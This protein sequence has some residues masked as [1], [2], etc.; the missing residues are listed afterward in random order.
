MHKHSARRR[1]VRCADKTLGCELAV[2]VRHEGQDVGLARLR[3]RRLPLEYYV[4]E[5]DIPRPRRRRLG[6]RVLPLGRPLGQ[7]PLE[8]IDEVLLDLDRAGRPRDAGDQDRGEQRTIVNI[9]VFVAWAR[10]GAQEAVGEGRVGGCRGEQQE[11]GEHR[12]NVS[13]A[14]QPFHVRERRRG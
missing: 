3:P 9:E 13:Q 4:V 12:G 2:E 7:L 6:R 1:A 5:W 14:G 10:Y 11:E 8:E